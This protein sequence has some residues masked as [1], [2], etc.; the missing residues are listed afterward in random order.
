MELVEGE[1]LEQQFTKRPLP[2]E[3]TICYSTQIAD[4]L[5]KA[6]RLGVTHRDLKPSSI[7]LAKIGA[8]LMDFGLAKQSGPAP[9]ATT[10]TEM[11]VDQQNLTS[12]GMLV[13]KLATEETPVTLAIRLNKRHTLK[14]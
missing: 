1:T 12:Q 4:A 10:L 7:M 9:L 5:A 8:K 6:H 13:G 14:L 11:T 2:T 3:Q